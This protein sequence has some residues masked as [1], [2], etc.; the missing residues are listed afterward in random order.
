M[1]ISIMF[2]GSWEFTRFFYIFDNIYHLI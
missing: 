2:L 1:F